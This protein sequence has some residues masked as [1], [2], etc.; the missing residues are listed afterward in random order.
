MGRKIVAA[1]CLEHI[2]KN[3]NVEVVGVLTDNHLEISPTSDIAKSANIPILSFDEALTLTENEYLTYDLGL[4]MLYWRKL[5][6]G[7]LHTPKLGTINFHPAPLPDYKG[8]GGYNLAIL[9]NLTEW[10]TTA[11]YV[12]EDI[13][14]GDIIEVKRFDI[15]PQKETAKSL[16]AISQQ[17]LFE[18]FQSI[19]DRVVCTD[20]TLATS[21]NVGGRYLSRVELEQMKEIDFDVDDIERKIRAFWFPPYHGAT[22]TVEGKKY[23]LVNEDILDQLSDPNSSSLFTAKGK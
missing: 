9:E 1:R 19:L 10:A 18:Q 5:R 17:I 23:T 12:D 8:V 21:S 16:E 4:S 15:D 13:D 11:H 14:T 22:I 3:T 7:L 20:G 6:G 2:V